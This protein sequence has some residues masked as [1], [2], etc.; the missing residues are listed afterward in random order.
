MGV[1]FRV[2]KTGK[3]FHPKPS[4]QSE[5]SCVDE[6]SEHSKEG[7]RTR[8]REGDDVAGIS[9]SDGGHDISAEHEVSFSLNLY[10]D[11][12]SIGKPPEKE[13]AHQGSLQ[14]VPKSLHSY[15]RASETLF[16]AIESGRL[17]GDILDDIP[18]K[19]VDGTLVCEVR[20]YRNCGSEQ[21][22]TARTVDG[23]PTINKVRLKMSLE[24]VVKD[25]PLISDNSWTY[26]D[27]MEVESRILKALQPKLCLDPTPKL[28][29][30]STNPVPIK[31]MN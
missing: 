6:V 20:D 30:L 10:P 13:A 5:T 8:K 19:Y 23:S 14:N 22:S 21:G 31:V 16:S 29:R 2:S 28:D 27:L 26:G 17:P 4:L 12:Y 1:S 7:S 25:I 15:D 3:R 18:C 24:N 9:H 11:G